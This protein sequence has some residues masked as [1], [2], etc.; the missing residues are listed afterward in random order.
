MLLPRCVNLIFRSSKNRYLPTVGHL[1][2]TIIE[3]PL[4]N[5]C[6]YGAFSTFLNV[7]LVESLASRL[8]V[9]M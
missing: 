4:V 7:S 6:V 1:D 3:N 2:F 8:P 9:S 5:I